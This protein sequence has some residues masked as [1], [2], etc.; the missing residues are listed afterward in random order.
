MLRVTAIQE[1][2]LTR[3]LVFTN[4]LR[5]QQ[6]TELDRSDTDWCSETFLPMLFNRQPASRDFNWEAGMVCY[7]T[8]SLMGSNL[9]QCQY[10]CASADLHTTGLRNLHS[11]LEFQQPLWQYSLFILTE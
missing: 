4:S 8:A 11:I 2:H 9:K 7:C 6:L 5:I 1:H 10:A 3:R